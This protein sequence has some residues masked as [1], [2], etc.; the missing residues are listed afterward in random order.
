MNI[1]VNLTVQD[2]IQIP[3]GITINKC[4]C[5]FKTLKNNRAWKKDYIWNPAIS[6]CKNGKYLASIMDDSI[7][8]CDEFTETTKSVPTKTVATKSTSLL[9]LMTYLLIAISLLIGVG[10]FQYLMKCQAK[11]QLKD[12]FY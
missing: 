11:R 9:I 1:N 7:I 3:S 4:W 10:I 8:T 5:E 6:S 2:L 12:M